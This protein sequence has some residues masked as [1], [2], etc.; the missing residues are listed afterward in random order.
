MRRRGMR[1][2]RPMRDISL[3]VTAARR[4]LLIP[5]SAR[6]ASFRA[7][8]KADADYG[9]TAQPDW[10]QTQFGVRRLEL[11]GRA[12]NVIELGSGP[13]TPALFVHGL[14]GTW[15]NWL[16]NLP[17]FALDRRVIALDLPGFGESEL[18]AGEI[19]ISGYARCVEQ[20]CRQ[21]GLSEIDLIGNS[22]GGFV[23]AELALTQPERVRRLALVD[24]AGISIVDL[25]RWP[26]R[27]AMRLI[28]VQAGWGSAQRSIL[29][30]PR[31][32]HM[33]FRAVMRHP[34]RLAIDL[35]AEQAGGP[36]MPGFLL[37]M[38]ALL[39]YDFR[40]RLSEIRCP[41]LI[42]HGEEDM[43]VPVAD[44]HEFRRLIDGSQLLLLKDTGHVPML[45]RPRTF[46]RAL[47]EFLDG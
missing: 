1:C 7:G 37:A 13:R 31:L 45:E 38:D 24:A 5:S 11:D 21:L 10:R 6:P 17:M 43:L 12:V 36:G 28:A 27:T 46:N 2:G 42:V 20:V 29:L 3:L 9:A 8:L 41:T 30:R 35:V 14:G 26:A 44:A 39:S 33:A 19:S 15:K 22:M 25:L 34:T 18:P 40:D 23:S 47:A 16:E 4:K 32:R